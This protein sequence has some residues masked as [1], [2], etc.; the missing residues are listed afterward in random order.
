[1][2]PSPRRKPATAAK[3]ETAA[4]STFPGGATIRVG[5]ADD[6]SIFRGRLRK[7]LQGEPD[8]EVAAEV[9]SADEAVALCENTPPDLLLLDIEMGGSTGM[10]VLERLRPLRLPTKVLILTAAISRTELVKALQLGARGAVIKDTP[11]PLLFKSIRRVRAGEFWIG[12]DMVGDLVQALATAEKSSPIKSALQAPRAFALT[13]RE[14]EIVSTVAAG[15]TNKEMATKFGVAE[16]TIK[17]H[18]TSIFDKTG[19]SSR[20]ELALFAIHHRLA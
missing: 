3:K 12:R 8:F 10:S 16:D 2:S 13:A 19:V 20:L 1:M 9:S 7:Q 4:G 5:L 17:H 15:Y 18:L 14:L 11:S 6:H